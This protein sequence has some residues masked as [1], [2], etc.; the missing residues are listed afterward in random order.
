MKIQIKDL[1]PNPFRDMDNYPI[2]EEKVQSLTNSINQ[3]GFWDNILVRPKPGYTFWTKQI[4]DGEELDEMN[5][6]CYMH[7]TYDE[8]GEEEDYDDPIFEIAYGHHR[9]IVLKK[10]FKPD[11][12]VDIPVKELDDPTMIRIMANENMNEWEAN[13]YIID[14]TINVANKYLLNHP[15]LVEKIIFDCD[16]SKAQMHP[17]YE[18]SSKIISEFL[19]NKLWYR[20]R[21]AESL[22]RLKLEKENKLNKEAIEKLPHEKTAT[23][24]TRQVENIKNITPRQQKKAVKQIIEKQD[25]SESGMKSALLDEKYRGKEKGKEERDFIEFKTYVM[26]CTKEIN[27]LN[28][29]LGK[30]LLLEEELKPDMLLYR[31]SIE[32]R[33]FDS[34][35][36]LLI[37]ILKGFL[38]KGET[39][40]QKQIVSKQQ[41]RK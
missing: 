8:N 19:G 37:S 18:I 16:L 3:T 35:L 25:F 12:Y 17:K 10:L 39:E 21:V 34:A 32:A 28:G 13:I 7:I 27:T 30:L 15:E 36:R 33:D 9:L 31:G 2:N 4:D 26:G 11:D 29:K 14:E 40:C 38:G 20:Q 24:F 5:A 22:K 23:V 6:P 1:R 41:S